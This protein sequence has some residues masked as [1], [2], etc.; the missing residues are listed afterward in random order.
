[1]K[2]EDFDNGTAEAIKRLERDLTL[3]SLAGLSL[4][5]VVW[6]VGP[7]M[8]NAEYTQL[9]AIVASALFIFQEVRRLR[10]DRLREE[11]A[12]L[13]ERFTLRKLEHDDI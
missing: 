5:A 13:Y 6:A 11:R 3:T 12:R 10:I 2:F 9:F 1:M 7:E 8:T 4:P